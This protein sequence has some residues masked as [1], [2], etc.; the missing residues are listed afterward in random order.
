[1]SGNNIVNKLFSGKRNQGVMDSI[2]EED[3]MIFTPTN[4]YYEL[5]TRIH[6]KMLDLMDLTL[7]DSLDQQILRKEIGKLIE[8]I[9]YEESSSVPLNLAE[10]EQLTREI[11]DEVL[12]LGPLEPLLQDPVISDILVNTYKQIYV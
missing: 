7:I 11:Q 10:R 2:P 6:D 5:K 1:M 3:P 8:K 4:E 9:L 12:G